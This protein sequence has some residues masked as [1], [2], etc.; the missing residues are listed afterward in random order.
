M[1]NTPVLV[2][3]FNRPQLL[4]Q[5][6]SRLQSL[7]IKDIYVSLDGPRNFDDN[8][9]CQECINI[10]KS[11][12]DVFNLKLIYRSYNLGCALGVVSAVDW[13]FENVDFGAIIE[14]DCYPGENLFDFFEKFKINKLQ[15]ESKNIKMA[16]AHNPFS[17]S[18]RDVAS[19]SILIHGWATWSEN[20]KL[21]RNNYFKLNLP[22]L[23]NSTGEKRTFAESVYWWANSTRARLGIIDTWD[24]MLNDRVWRLGYKTLVPANNMIRNLGFGENATHTKDPNGSN[25]IQLPNFGKVNISID[26]LLSEYYFKIN[27]RHLL[28]SFIRVFIDLV[29]FKKTN[30]EKYLEL[31]KS[32]R[33]IFP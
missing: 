8:E 26:Q 1:N 27:N 12:Q 29:K 31:D 17:N 10:V 11:F 9:I 28:T 7:N 6:L 2:I 18:F 3:G 15:F 5:L 4:S 23:K 24:G 32:Q 30:F 33:V 14:D 13:F 22:N 21:I 20:W 19:N 16:T 25:L